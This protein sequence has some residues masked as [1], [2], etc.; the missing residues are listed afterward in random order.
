VIAPWREWDLTSRTKLLEFAEANQIPIAKDKRGEAPFGG[1]QPAAHLVRRQGAGKPGRGS[2]D[3][4]YQRTV[5][6]ED[7]PDTP[8]Y[9]RNHLRAGDAVAINGERL[10]PATMLT[11]LNELGGKHGVGRAGSGG[12]PLCRHE[13]ARRL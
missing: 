13:V 3:Y 4:V 8:T 7:A 9:G 12:K 11:R 6:V 10:S 1:R 2:P 5:A